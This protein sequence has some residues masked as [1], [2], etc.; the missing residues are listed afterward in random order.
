MRI[1][2]LFDQPMK[3]SWFNTKGGNKEAFFKVD[4]VRY[5]VA[6]SSGTPAHDQIVG[7]TFGI[8]GKAHS[9]A[10]KDAS[11]STRSKHKTI[12][13]FST[14]MAA[15][16]S[17]FKKENIDVMIFTPSAGRQGE[18]YDR[19]AKYI[20]SVHPEYHITQEYDEYNEEYYYEI[21]K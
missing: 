14:V 20:N 16:D 12:Q 17:Y 9:Y 21:T 7:I 18:M 10:T 6:F 11:T 8:Y 2:E 1:D 5:K 19:I 15:I 3:L 4:G 13:I